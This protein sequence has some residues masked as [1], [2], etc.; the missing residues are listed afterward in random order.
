MDI[1]K[2]AYE[3]YKLN[4]LMEHGYTLADI[5]R[6]LDVIKED[7]EDNDSIELLFDFW[8]DNYGFSSEIWACYQEFIDNEYQDTDY[9]KQILTNDEYKKYQEDLNMNNRISAIEK[10]A[11]KREE[12]KTAK[13]MELLRQ[14]EEY[15]A[16]IRALKSRIDELLEI[17]NACLTHNIP[18][19]GER[20]GGHQGYDTHQFITNSWSHLLGF[21]S[22]Y[23]KTTR[24]RK[25]F[26]NVG[27]Y[28]GGACNFNLVTDGVT[29]N[30]DGKDTLYV[31]KR[32]VD[33][34]DTFESEF[35]K[36]IDVV[37]EKK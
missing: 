8:E 27:I 22:E 19:E 26:K 9:M 25:P 30:L 10:F 7:E 34:F 23:D 1:K 28:G 6:E 11:Q 35:Y 31:L 4:W 32:F 14:H 21:V 33:E 37:C 36:Y 16:R 13:E 18:L 2:I 5:I 29:I 17:G 3:K 15:K 20:W 24:K 12:E